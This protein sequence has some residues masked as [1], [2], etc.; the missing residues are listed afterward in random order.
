MKLRQFSKLNFSTKFSSYT[1]LS[2]TTWIGIFSAASVMTLSILKY[3]WNCRFTS[4]F[5]FTQNVDTV[6]DSFDER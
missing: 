2:K 6:D 1:A 3:G 4:F 5:S